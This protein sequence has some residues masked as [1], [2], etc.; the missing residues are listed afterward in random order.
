MLDS[1][2]HMT[3]NS[4]VIKFLHDRKLFFLFLKQ[5]ICCGYLKELSQ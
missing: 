4:F 1:L 2:Y 5:N 3:L